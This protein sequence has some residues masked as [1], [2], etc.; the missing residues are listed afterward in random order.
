V[1]SRDEWN[2][3]QIDTLATSR[4]KIYPS[5][6]ENDGFDY[7]EAMDEEQAN[8]KSMLYL[9]AA[10]GDVELCDY[11]IMSGEDPLKKESDGRTCVGVALANKHFEVAELLQQFRPDA[12]EGYTVAVPDPEE[13]S[14]LRRQAEL[15]RKSE[16]E[17]ARLELA[18]RGVE[19][20]E[21]LQAKQDAHL[22][23]QE[24]AQKDAEL[25]LQRQAQKAKI[26]SDEAERRVKEVEQKLKDE[27]CAEKKARELKAQRHKEKLE[28]EASQMVHRVWRDPIEVGEKETEGEI[29]P[30]VLHDASPTKQGKV[31][32]SM[33]RAAKKA[34]GYTAQR[35]ESMRAEEPPSPPRRRPSREKK[36]PSSN[37]GEEAESKSKVKP[38]PIPATMKGSPKHQKTPSRRLKGSPTKQEEVIVEEHTKRESQQMQV[39]DANES[40]DSIDVNKDG[41]I[42]RD[43]WMQAQRKGQ[44]KRYK[45]GDIY[46][47]GLVNE[48]RHGYGRC[49]FKT[50]AEYLGE[51]TNDLMHGTGC[52]KRGEE[53]YDG[54]W[55]EGSQSG[56][57]VYISASGGKYEGEWKDG[58]RHGQG[59]YLYENGDH[60][61]GE[62][63]AGNR[64]GSGNYR[65]GVGDASYQG[66][67]KGDLK[68]GFGTMQSDGCTYAGGWEADLYHGFGQLTQEDGHVLVGIWGAGVLVEQM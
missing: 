39:K 42:S 32:R 60:Y 24:Q 51:W 19:E 7:E 68:S 5:S 11:L 20:R 16:Q 50:G 48:L 34:S 35:G 33:L 66:T 3:T 58:D 23:L 44:M 56:N 59:V 15:R 65:G 9:A 14:E 1:I 52:L 55:S 21:A 17:A 61:S 38:S 25:L 36:R 12:P 4:D 67:W 31:S 6:V 10:V 40:F 37:G 26:V 54:Q 29:W 8:G 64:E 27:R 46:G 43:E 57:G 41:V 18:R 53:S 49:K 13:E 2:K 45:N 22:L 47:G 28:A 63:V 62:W 30:P